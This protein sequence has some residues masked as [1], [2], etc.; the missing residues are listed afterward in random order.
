[1]IRLEELRLAVVFLTR[2]PAGRLRAPIPALGDARW[3]FPIVGLLVGGLTALAFVALNATGLSPLLVAA[4][5]LAVQA[6]LTGALHFDGLADVADGLGGGRDKAHALEIMRDS[7][8][9]SYG[10][11]A[12]GLTAL[13]WVIALADT[14]NGPLALIALAVSSRLAMLIVLT[15]LPSARAD[16]LGQQ[17]STGRR[18]Y[19]PGI[20]LTAVL[21]VALGP[22][23]LAALTAMALATAF[24][25]HRAMKR[26]G[27]QTGDVCGA[28]QLLSETAGLIALS[29]L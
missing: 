17:A 29:T 6:M 3:A 16:G 5:T 9:G 28:A 7:R 22:S 24:L 2:L 13:I 8:L 19:L 20:L 10:A 25:A 15:E 27:G 21:M 4:L 11:L 12:L 26:I 23:A 18:A 1:M 14:P